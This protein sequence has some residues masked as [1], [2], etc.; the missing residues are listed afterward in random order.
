MIKWWVNSWDNRGLHWDW[1]PRDPMQISREQAA[2]KRKKN[3]GP[4]SKNP[5]MPGPLERVQCQLPDWVCP[6]S[7]FVKVWGLHSENQ[8]Y[9]VVHL[10]WSCACSTGLGRTLPSLDR[11][12]QLNC[13]FV[14]SLSIAGGLLG[15]TR[16][17]R[18]ASITFNGRV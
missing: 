18:N 2:K 8:G 6:C 15:V 1:V 13:Q 5:W 12:G 16:L 11:N 9:H 7:Y 3:G 4:G 10:L 14:M 17:L